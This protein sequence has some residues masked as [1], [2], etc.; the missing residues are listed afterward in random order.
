ML[1]GTT[2]IPPPPAM[3]A[4]MK[5]EGIKGDG[6]TSVGVVVE[7]VVAAME[8]LDLTTSTSCL[9]CSKGTRRW[10][11]LGSLGWR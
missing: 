9:R 1:D 6:L 3:A 4:G 7:V 2:N 8:A 10:T 5:G 11:W